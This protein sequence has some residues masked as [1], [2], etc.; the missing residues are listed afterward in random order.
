MACQDDFGEAG[1]AEEFVDGQEV[2]EEFNDDRS[3]KKLNPKKVRQARDEEN[4]WSSVEAHVEECVKVTGKKPIQVR[5]VDVDKGFGVYRSRFV[6]KDFG[7]KNNIDDREG[8]YAA[9][10]VDLVP[11]RAKAGKCKVLVHF[12]TGCGLLPA[13]GSGS[14]LRIWRRRDL[15][16]GL[17]RS[18]HSSTPRGRSLV[19]GRSAACREDVGRHRA[20][21]LQ[22]ESCVRNPGGRRSRTAS[23]NSTGRPLGSTGPSSPGI[24]SFAQDRLDIRYTV[25]ELCREMSCPKMRSWAALKNLC[26]NLRGVPRMVQ[27]VP[28]VGETSEYLEIFVDSDWAGCQRTTKSTNGCGIMWYGA[29]LKVW[30]TTQTVIATSSGEAEYCAAVKGGTEGLAMHTMAK[31]LGTDTKIRVHTDG[32]ACRGIGGGLASEGQAHGGASPLATGS[33]PREEDRNG[34]DRGEG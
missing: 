31:D 3:G 12:C 22:A 18:A 27:R 17:H 20:G 16:R 4:W 34:T 26:R 15:F 8:L 14:T 30:S 6:A 13:A 5:W 9:Q 23:W 21:G 25:K 2:P 33:R 11:E 32:S 24:T 1:W 10:Y 7:P 19:G 29:C 28:I